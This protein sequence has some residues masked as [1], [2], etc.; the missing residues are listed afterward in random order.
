MRLSDEQLP[1]LCIFVGLV[2]IFS[3]VRKREGLA[4]GGTGGKLM[5]C[6]EKMTKIDSIYDSK[7]LE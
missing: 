3:S 7:E 1:C 5:G 6:I 4:G 2:V